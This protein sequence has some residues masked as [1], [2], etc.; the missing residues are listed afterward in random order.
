MVFIAHTRLLCVH[1]MDA[2]L[3]PIDRFI[4]ENQYVL[5]T[6]FKW[7]DVFENLSN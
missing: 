3:L 5:R 4:S 2:P 6:S 7:L 1:V